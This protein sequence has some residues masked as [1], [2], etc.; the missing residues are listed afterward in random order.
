MFLFNKDIEDE[1][2]QTSISNITYSNNTNNNNNQHEENNNQLSNFTYISHNNSDSHAID[3]S[4]QSKCPDSEK[5]SNTNSMDHTSFTCNNVDNN[6]ITQHHE[7]TSNT[8]LKNLAVLAFLAQIGEGVISDWSTLY[9]REVLQSS[10]SVSTMG[11]TVFALSMAIGRFNTDRLLNN[12]HS[13]MS[14]L[15]GSGFLSFVGLCIVVVSPSLP[16]YD[17]SVLVAL[18]GLCISGFGLSMIFPIVA[19]CSG[20]IPG[21]SPSDSIATVTSAGYL[22]FLVGP[23]FFGYVSDLLHNLRWSLLIGAFLL[24]LVGIVPWTVPATTA[25]SSVSIHSSP[26]TSPNESVIHHNIYYS[27]RIT[28][29]PTPSLRRLLSLRNDR[30]Y[31]YQSIENLNL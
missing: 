17:V 30:K 24:L 7:H 2:H 10:P 31:D 6:S 11:F 4:D 28:T 9:F 21:T 18:F 13:N 5:V 25:S 12:K 8:Y 23:P 20:N 15:K 29:P 3:I 14:I 16:A 19:S 1:I 27:E 22:G 26:I